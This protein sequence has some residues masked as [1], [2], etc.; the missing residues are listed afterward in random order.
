MFPPLLL[1]L[2]SSWSCILTKYWNVVSRYIGLS[3]IAQSSIRALW[4]KLVTLVS[5]RSIWKLS[6][7]KLTDSNNSTEGRRFFYQHLNINISQLFQSLRMSWP[8]VHYGCGGAGSFFV[9]RIMSPPCS[10]ILS[11]LDTDTRSLPWINNDHTP[12]LSLIFYWIFV[13]AE[14]EYSWPATIILKKFTINH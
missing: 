14:L 10:L 11:Y 13:Y 6:T 9:T 4:D 8:R 1:V 3:V 2:L 12:A 7:N 5:K